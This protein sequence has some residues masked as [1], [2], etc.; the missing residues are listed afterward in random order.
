MP[1][2]LDVCSGWLM[3][4]FLIKTADSFDMTDKRGINVDFYVGAK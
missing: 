3:F 1:V 2:P 4:L